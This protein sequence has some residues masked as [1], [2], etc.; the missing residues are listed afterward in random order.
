[1]ATDPLYT[2]G[3]ILGMV[4][5][6][7]GSAYKVAPTLNLLDGNLQIAPSY[8]D[9]V[10]TSAP[11]SNE[12]DLQIIYN[13]PQIKGFTVFTG[14]GYVSQSEQQGGDIYQAQVMFSYLY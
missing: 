4:Q 1:M 5:R 11:T 13:I 14:Y 12:Y 3:F 8:E 9:F 10:T 6:S 7:A 2:T